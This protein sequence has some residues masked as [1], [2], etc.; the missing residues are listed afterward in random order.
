MTKR[1]HAPAHGRLDRVERRHQV[2]VEDDVRR[3]AGRLGD[4]RGVDHRVVAAHDREGRAGVGEVGLHVRGLAGVGALEHG[5]PEVGRRSRRGR[6]ASRASTVARP[7]LPRA[8]VTRMRMARNLAGCSRRWSPWRPRPAVAGGSCR[9]TRPQ[10]PQA[11]SEGRVRAPPARTPSLPGRAPPF[12]SRS[13]SVT[14]FAAAL[15]RR[16]RCVRALRRS[17]AA[18]VVALRVCEPS[19]ARASSNPLAAGRRELRLAADCASTRRRKQGCAPGRPLRTD[20]RPGYAL[21]ARDREG[22]YGSTGLTCR[23]ERTSVADAGSSEGPV[24]RRAR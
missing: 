13:A 5:R 12:A 18:A 3:V 11:P 2:V 22:S 1:A 24:N 17:V 16:A 9:R 8:P 19:C 15:L 20:R 7:T 6:R 21:G 10:T 23:G 14:A 4:R